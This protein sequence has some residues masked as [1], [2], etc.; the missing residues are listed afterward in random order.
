MTSLVLACEGGPFQLCSIA[1]ATWRIK[2]FGYS[3]SGEIVERRQG[4]VHQSLKGTIISCVSNATSQ[5]TLRGI[6]CNDREGPIEQAAR[7]GSK[8]FGAFDATAS[9]IALLLVQET[10]TGR[11]LLRQP[12]LPSIHKGCVICCKGERRWCRS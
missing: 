9:A 7:I 6:V 10:R 2:L 5:I 4:V 1:V 11:S 3:R 12:P 8:R